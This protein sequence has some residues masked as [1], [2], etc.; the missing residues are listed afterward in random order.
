MVRDDFFWQ[1]GR[2]WLDLVNTERMRDGVRVDLLADTEA[3]SVWWENLEGAGSGLVSDGTRAERED[4][5]QQA[6]ALRAQLRSLCEEWDRTPGTIPDATVENLNTWLRPPAP[7][8]RLTSTEDGW[9]LE[10]ALDPHE[11]RQ[12]LFPLARA[13]ATS[14]ANGELKLL[15]KCGNPSCIRWFLDTSKNHSRRWCSM[16]AC[17]N[18]H[19]VAE[20]YRKQRTK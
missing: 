14:I 11:L 8:L 18:R 1:G 12:V 20:H 7:G 16:D 10:D 5:L 6:K 9:R 13:A 17:G 19:K 3:L 4:L 15:R 2:I